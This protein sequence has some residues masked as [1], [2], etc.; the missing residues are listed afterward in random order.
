MSAEP[1]HV[2]DARHEPRDANA[3]VY[4]YTS[5]ET[6]RDYI[7]PSNTL[8]LSP[9]ENVND[10]KESKYSQ[11]FG[12]VSTSPKKLASDTIK[13]RLREFNE[14]LIKV[15]CFS[16]DNPNI[17]LQFDYSFPGYAKPTMWAHYGS[18]HSGVCLMFDRLKLLARFNEHFGTYPRTKAGN[19]NYQFLTAIS[20]TEIRAVN[21]TLPP[22]SVVYMLDEFEA[23]FAQAALGRF[24]EY[25]EEMYFRK[26]GDWSA[27]SEYRLLIVS[28]SKGFEFL[29]F[30]DA[31]VGVATGFD[32]LEGIRSELNAT[33]DESGI[34]RLQMGPGWFTG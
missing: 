21:R 27:E 20:R 18:A 4:H 34:R 5:V 28:E 19:V 13:E 29:P 10:P 32:M 3:F 23:D 30:G 31:L 33:L 14:E 12:Y 9:L 15:A 1:P 25:A 17:S 6:F 2:L 11:S 8:R 16:R 22:G 26:H 7:L 24:D